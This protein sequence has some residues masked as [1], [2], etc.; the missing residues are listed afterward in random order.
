MRP[1]APTKFHMVQTDL[2]P[3]IDFGRLKWLNQWYTISSYEFSTNDKIWKPVNKKQFTWQDINFIW[4]LAFLFVCSILGK[5]PSFIFSLQMSLSFGNVPT[6]GSCEHEKRNSNN[7]K[8][9]SKVA[10]LWLFC[11]VPFIFQMDYII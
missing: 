2:A 9:V 6:I 8:R 4:I 1:N 11:H 3:D 7:Q 10:H 5:F